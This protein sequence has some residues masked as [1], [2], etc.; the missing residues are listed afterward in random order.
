M[1]CN[2]IATA[3]RRQG[4]NLK[5]RCPSHN[6]R[7]LQGLARTLILVVVVCN[8]SYHFFIAKLFK[9][10]TCV[11]SLLSLFT[12]LDICAKNVLRPILGHWKYG[13]IWLSWPTTALGLVA[14][15]GCNGDCGVQCW[16]IKTALVHLTRF[17]TIGHRKGP[18]R[19]LKRI[20]WCAAQTGQ[21]WPI[22][23]GQVCTVVNQG[24]PGSDRGF[25]PSEIVF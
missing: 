21:K 18:N 17:W 22:Q 19:T 23:S 24:L 3:N 2:G 8:T 5:T 10:F 20:W 16:T 1:V 12:S 6:G 4:T 7:P 15:V 14:L 11:F 9:C 25:K 13:L